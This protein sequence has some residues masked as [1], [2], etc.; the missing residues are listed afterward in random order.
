MQTTF[1]IYWRIPPITPYNGVCAG[2]DYF[3]VMTDQLAGQS[4]RSIERG[5]QVTM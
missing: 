1:G 3:E 5:F 4:P 2:I